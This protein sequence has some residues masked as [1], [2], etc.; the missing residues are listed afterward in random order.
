MGGGDEVNKNEKIKGIIMGC[1]LQAAEREMYETSIFSVC[2]GILPEKYLF[3][4]VP[5]QLD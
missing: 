5:V 2:Q 4:N 3:F 1:L